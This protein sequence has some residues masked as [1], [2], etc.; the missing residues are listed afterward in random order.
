[1]LRAAWRRRAAAAQNATRL[2]LNGGKVA[3]K[4]AAAAGGVTVL[5][6]RHRLNGGGGGASAAA[7]NISSS[8]IMAHQRY[9]SIISHKWHRRRS[10]IGVAARRLAARVAF[11]GVAHRIAWRRGIIGAQ[12]HNGEV[13]VVVRQADG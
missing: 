4:T 2:A 1:M 9:P 12:R 6:M 3:A 13:P 11:I 10:S 7:L 5:G 8:K